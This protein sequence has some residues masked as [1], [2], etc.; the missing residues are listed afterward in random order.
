MIIDGFEFVAEGNEKLWMRTPYPVT[1]N[2][3]DYFALDIFPEFDVDRANKLSGRDPPAKSGDRYLNRILYQDKDVAE[4]ADGQEGEYFRHAWLPDD[5]RRGLDIHDWGLILVPSEFEL[6]L[7][8]I[9]AGF[10]KNPEEKRKTLYRR[11]SQE[12]TTLEKLFANFHKVLTSNLIPGGLYACND[13]T[14]NDI[15]KF[16]EELVKCF[17]SRLALYIRGDFGKVPYFNKS[18][19]S[20]RALERQTSLDFMRNL[21]DVLLQEMRFENINS[22]ARISSKMYSMYRHLLESEPKIRTEAKETPEREVYAD[23]FL[24]SL[25]ELTPI[26]ELSQI[27]F[28]TRETPERKADDDFFLTL[29]VEELTPLEEH[30]E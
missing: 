9:E 26:E 8:K 16:R 18:I 6:Y 30:Q 17:D 12:R 19:S 13:T 10:H 1:H 11:A 14:I 21:D 23:F 22:P 7:D 24:T 5:K 4:I 15:R 27:E 25:E 29:E 3:W 2:V 28:D 20:Y